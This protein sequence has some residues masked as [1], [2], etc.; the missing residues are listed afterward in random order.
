[1][2]KKVSA[3]LSY[4]L[5]L[6]IV[7]VM[8]GF[9]G[10]GIR[11]FTSAVVSDFIYFIALGVFLAALT[12][13]FV[14]R[15]PRVGVAIDG[16]IRQISSARSKQVPLYAASVQKDGRRPLAPGQERVAVA[17]ERRSNQLAGFRVGSLELNASKTLR[18]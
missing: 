4:A 7:L 3:R 15:R 5:V 2:T 6:S 17:H 8:I 18:A 16:K 1:M 9:L 14:L 13:Y 10:L 11:A 12:I